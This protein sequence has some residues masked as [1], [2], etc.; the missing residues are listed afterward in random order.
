MC[1]YRTVYGGSNTGICFSSLFRTE[2]RTKEMKCRGGFCRYMNV[3][4]AMRPDWYEILCDA[5][6]P[7]NASKKRLSKST[8][9]SKSYLTQCLNLHRESKVLFSDEHAV[10]RNVIVL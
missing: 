5:D 1:P 3:V 4:E 8:T 6:T 2:T 9:M 7:P 10:D